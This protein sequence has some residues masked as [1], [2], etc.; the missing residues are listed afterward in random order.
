MSLR[1]D[2][3]GYV[4]AILARTEYKYI[5]AVL[6]VKVQVLIYDFDD[7]SDTRH[8]RKANDVR[9]DERADGQELIVEPH[10]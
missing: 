7:Y 8:R 3:F 6:T 5:G 1:T 4:N 10:F 9:D 2:R